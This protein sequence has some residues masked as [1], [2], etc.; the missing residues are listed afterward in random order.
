M[1][2]VMALDG[3]VFCCYLLAAFE[4]TD[5]GGED[6]DGLYRSSAVV[7]FDLS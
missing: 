4:S 1:L 5:I 6:I 3:I 7:C 2:S